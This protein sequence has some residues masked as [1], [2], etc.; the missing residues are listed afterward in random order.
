MT[1]EALLQ[2]IADSNRAIL[3]CLQSGAAV[4]AAEFAPGNLAGA[5]AGGADDGKT[6]TRKRRTKEEIAADEAAAAAAK[7]AADKE[8]AL[9]ASATAIANK[10]QG[11]AGAADAGAAGAAGATTGG[12]VTWDAAVAKLKALAQ[13]PAHG[14]TA[15][16]AVIK[17]ID[18]NAA[19]VPALKDLNKN[20]EIVAA[21]DALLNPAAAAG[22]EVD[23]LFG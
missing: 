2:D 21:I 11:N 18:P 17:K 19:N 13:D 7:A 20:A 15:V 9:S 8:A 1:I 6:T 4:A 14:S 3:A 12:E 5:T 16:M 23:P 22:A 10:N